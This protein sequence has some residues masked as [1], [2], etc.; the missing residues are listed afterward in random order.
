M[1]DACG[2]PDITDWDKDHVDL[3]WTPP[4]NDGGAPIEKYIIEKKE[5]NGEWEPAAEVP[6][7]QT[8]GTAPNL[9]EGK[10]YQFRV[11][12]VNKGGPGAPSEPTEPK[13]AK[14]RHRKSSSLQINGN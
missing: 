3:K 4:K 13:I 6:A 10:E 9:I 12:A 8:S 7:E 2:K 1:P 11:R 14:P 5:K